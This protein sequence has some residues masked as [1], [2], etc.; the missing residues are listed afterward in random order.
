M[1]QDFRFQTREFGSGA[2]FLR[3]FRIDAK[4]HDFGVQMSKT[5]MIDDRNFQNV[6][7]IL[8]F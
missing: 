7:R 2:D 1:G 8:T 5:K 6:R 4:M 3:R